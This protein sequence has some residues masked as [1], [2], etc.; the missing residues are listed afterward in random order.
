MDL[1]N[2]EHLQKLCR[3]YHLTPSKKY[4]QNFL[5]DPAIIEIILEVAEL[6]SS[7]TVLEVGPGLGVLTEK[8]APRVQTVFAF[9]IEKKLQSY[10]EKRQKE[11]QNIHIIWGN[12]L[13]EIEH[14]PWPVEKYKVVANLP[15][16]ITSAVIR[17]FLEHTVFPNMMVLMVQK[18]VAERICAEPGQMS[19]LS[20]AVQLYSHPEYVQTV[21]R[22][23][24]WPSPQVDSAIIK[25]IPH[26]NALKKENTFQLFNLVK[27]GFSSRR[28][29]LRRNLE[30]FLGKEYREK[31]AKAF[32]SLNLASEVRAQELSVEQWI[33]LVQC[34]EGSV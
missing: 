22:T 17:L 11:L 19:L 23:A 31:V 8:L 25:L 34:L 32:E 13:R 28:K 3:I 16:Q 12:V 6:S 33:K 15:Y 5:I 27:A 18:E 14:L 1:Y 21:P 24:F 7:D 26:K 29:V 30:N 4:G 2:P 20:V 9:E 10:W